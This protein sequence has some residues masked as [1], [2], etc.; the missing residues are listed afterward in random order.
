VIKL[1]EKSLNVIGKTGKF[2]VKHPKEFWSGYK[3]ARKG[4]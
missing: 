1:G 3:M 4:M 2:V